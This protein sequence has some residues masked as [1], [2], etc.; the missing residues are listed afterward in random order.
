MRLTNQGFTLVEILVVSA[1]AALVFVGIFGGF[2]LAIEMTADARAKS[3]AVSIAN[4]QMEF[5][6]SLPYDAI[7]TVGGIP[8]GDIPQLATTTVSGREF[9]VR[10]LIYWVDDPADGLGVDDVNNIITDYKEAKVVVSWQTDRGTRSIPLFSRIAPPGMETDVGGGILRVQVNNRNFEPV[11]GATVRVLNETTTSTIDITQSTNDSGRVVIAGAPPASQYE[12]F[13]GK[14]GY[15]SE[16]TH[17]PTSTLPNPTNQPISVIEGET[18]TI[19][20]RIDQLAN[21]SLQFTQPLVPTIIH[22]DFDPP[23]TVTASS[24]V[25]LTTDG[26]Q[27]ADVSGSYA[28]TGTVQ[29]TVFNPATFSRWDTAIVTASTSPETSVRA[30]LFSAVGTTSPVWL[31]EAVLPGNTA[32]FL[33]GAIDLSELDPA[34]FS[35]LGLHVTLESSVATETPT[36]LDW[37]IGYVPTET[38]ETG[39]PVRIRGNKT[40]GTDA[41]GVSVRKYDE[42]HTSDSNGQILLPE[43]EW[44]S[45][46]VE[47][48]DNWVITSV[49]PWLP[50]ELDPGAS[51]D[52]RLSVITTAQPSLRVG[53]RDAAGAPIPNATVRVED[54]GFNAES[55]TDAC[56]QAFFGAGLVTGNEYDITVTATGFA[57]NQSNDVTVTGAYLELI[58]LSP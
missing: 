20:F 7:G 41:G 46:Q 52:M 55:T 4:G 35:E 34:T 18:A 54:G 58:T 12:I 57:T 53:V 32:G 50:L 56:G 43:M 26:Y 30:R 49:C 1:L 48:L 45:Y 23:T 39:V 36:L 8:A 16:Q 22:D 47:P 24:S 3:A 33:P 25:T 19:A 21:W 5:I 14:L 29:S 28:A 17:R 40:L 10:T 15:S 9:S 37:S 31:P 13:V 11:S 44:D 2:R 51:V 38:P 42:T 27:L 6:R